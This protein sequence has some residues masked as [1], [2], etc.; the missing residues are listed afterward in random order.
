MEAVS[1]YNMVTSEGVAIPLLGVNVAAVL[2][3]TALEATVCQHYQNT[4]TQTIEAVYT[5][6]LPVGAQLMSLVVYLNDEQHSA[7]VVEATQAEERYEQAIID[8]DSA[9]RLEQ[10]SDSLYTLNLG[11]LQPGDKASIKIHYAQLLEWQQEQLRLHI[12][13]TIGERYGNPSDLGMSPHQHTTTD[14]GV[15]H[16]MSLSVRVEGQLAASKV[17]CPSHSVGLQ[18]INGS[19]LIKPDTGAVFM[20]RDFVLLLKRPE[21]AT[22]AA[23]YDCDINGQ[24]LGWLS[25]NPQIDVTHKPRKLKIVVDCSGSMSGV[26]IQQA[27][28]AVREI[29]EQLQ[30]TD[31][32]NIINFGSHHIT[33]FHQPQLATEKN[34]AEAYQWVANTQADLGGTE[35][36]AALTAAYGNSSERSNDNQADLLLITDGQTYDMAAVI[37]R[38]KVSGHRHFTVGVGSAA[39][40]DLVRGLA[41]ATAG[42]CELVSP[43]EDMATAI[44]RH[45]QRSWLPAITE[46]MINWP[47][48]PLN[49]FPHKITHAFS[50]D[51]LHVFAQ[52]EQPP[53]GEVVVAI[54]FGQQLW[55]Q[56]VAIQA[57]ETTNQERSLNTMLL[58]RMAATKRMAVADNDEEKIALGIAYQLQSTLTNYLMVAERDNKD[59]SELGPAIRQV[60]QM[61]KADLSTENVFFSLCANLEE[62]PYEVASDVTN[63]QLDSELP[64]SDQL[65]SGDKRSFLP[66]PDF[67][68]KLRKQSEPISA[69]RRADEFVR[70]L[71]QSL[72]YAISNL[73][74]SLPRDTQGLD[75]LGLDELIVHKLRLWGSGAEGVGLSEIVAAYLYCFMQHCPAAKN[76][77][78]NA[79][80]AITKAYNKRCSNPVIVNKL[81]AQLIALESELAMDW[82]IEPEA[83][84]AS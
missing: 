45:C 51:T 56:T 35:M 33:L 66:A 65:E 46:A 60:P 10:I 82:R 9:M 8:G 61:S 27:K 7:K 57:F 39:A 54:Q 32:F 75:S 20:D 22:S 42:A 55:K 79:M 29:V 43:N 18:M 44:V 76:L 15:E 37:D 30:A 17:S 40:E 62:A 63:Y 73:M 68:I 49:Q 67:L 21:M 41:Q 53:Q 19:L 31:T 64:T 34:K 59:E 36:A 28:V 3:D 78:R 83:V 84:H 6:P 50:G 24:W 74:P 80:R 72:E 26:A 69:V 5:F 70:Q 47:Q 14:P 52:F 11:N 58:A 25:L 13:T 77:S 81:R 12:P 48:T 1:V 71:N 16:E 23:Y 4:E 2:K 38:A